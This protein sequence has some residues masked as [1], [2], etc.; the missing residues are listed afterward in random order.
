MIRPVVVAGPTATGKSALAVR[1]A[2]ALDGEIISGDSAQVYRGMDIGTAKLSAAEA[3][4]VPQHL[5]DILDIESPFSAGL[6]ARLAG[7]RASEIQSRGRVPL[8]VGGTGLYIDAL[9]GLSGFAETEGSDPAVRELLLRQARTE[10]AQS[11]HNRLASVDPESAAAIHP[12]NV[13]RVARALEIY[14]VTGKTKTALSA[15]NRGQSRFERCL[16]LLGT[17][18]R[19]ALYARIDARVDGMMR[20]GLEAEARAL[21]ERGLARTPTASQAIGYKEF[22]P[23]FEGL[24]DLETAVEAVKRATRNYAKRQVTYFRRMKDAFCIDCALPEQTVFE[25]ALRH[26]REFLSAP[27]RQ[28]DDGAGVCV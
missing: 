16:I 22:F 12:H 6:F 5:V 13:K 25:T 9:T 23:Y 19:A 14:L 8:V 4:G 20:A 24:A 17:E 28:R 10:G 15:E 3:H 1:L 27:E 18:D 7:E 11:L 21:W 26:C 2:Q